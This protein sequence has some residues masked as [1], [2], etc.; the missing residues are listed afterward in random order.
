M[1]HSHAFLLSGIWDN[2]QSDPRGCCIKLGHQQR[3]RKTD[4]NLRPDRGL[5]T[6]AGTPAFQE[7][8]VT[9]DNSRSTVW[10]CVCKVCCPPNVDGVTCSQGLPQ[11]SQGGLRDESPSWLTM[12]TLLPSLQSIPCHSLPQHLHYRNPAPARG[13]AALG[14]GNSLQASHLI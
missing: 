10:V 13:E 1:G 7:S 14:H 3:H 9:L 12:D 6:H 2:L 8:Q 5:K 4:G 11:N